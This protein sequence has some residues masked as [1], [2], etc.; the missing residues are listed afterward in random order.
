MPSFTPSPDARDPRWKGVEGVDDAHRFR[1]A[2]RSAS[3]PDPRRRRGRALRDRRPS[4]TK[5]EPRAASGG[6]REGGGP[7]P[8]NRAAQTLPC[9]ARVFRLPRRSR[10]RGSAPVSQTPADDSHESATW[11]GGASLARDRDGVVFHVEQW[12]SWSPVISW[13]GGS[14]AGM[15]HV[16]RSGQRTHPKSVALASSLCD[17]SRETP[18]GAPPRSQKPG[19][20]D[21]VTPPA[22]SL[23]PG[24]S[25]GLRARHAGAVLPS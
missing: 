24:P 11:P 18:P 4:G 15:F 22:L 20:A 10:Q 3:G 12:S 9:T 2:L 13:V 6:A 5:A 17:V 23:R 21:R 7:L 14:S 8:P 25:P 1:V 16:K 19:G